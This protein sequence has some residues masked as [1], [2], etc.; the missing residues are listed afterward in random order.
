M[1][2]FP[3]LPKEEKKEYGLGPLAPPD[4][5][6]ISYAKDLIQQAID[7]DNRG[8]RKLAGKVIE[9][10]IEQLEEYKT[11]V[12]R[13]KVTEMAD[14]WLEMQEQIRKDKEDCYKTGKEC[15]HNC[16]GQCRDSC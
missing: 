3:R 12:T 9:L 5:V 14:N 13:C 8:N 7:Y 4:P 1:G 10:A 16:P 2:G 11:I 15:K 6:H